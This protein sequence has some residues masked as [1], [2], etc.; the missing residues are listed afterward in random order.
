MNCKIDMGADLG[1]G[2]RAVEQIESFAK[3]IRS[4]AQQRRRLAFHLYP[5]IKTSDL[6]P[7]W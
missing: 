5:H 6:P 4:I 2:S 1:R 3:V 7:L